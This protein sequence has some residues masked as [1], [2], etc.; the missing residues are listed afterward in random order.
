MMKKH[1]FSYR[2]IVI[3]TVLALLTLVVLFAIAAMYPFN[4][5]AALLS[6][7]SLPVPNAEI[8]TWSTFTGVGTQLKYPPGWEGHIYTTQGGV[9]NGATYTFIWRDGQTLLAQID[10]LEVVTTD[11]T[12]LD[13]EMSYWQQNG[14]THNYSLEQVMAQGYPAWWIHTQ[15]SSGMKQPAGILWVAQ[16]ERSYRFRLYSQVDVQASSEQWLR[17]MVSTFQLATVDWG[18]TATKLV[19][20]MRTKLEESVHTP[21]AVLSVTYNRGQ[22]L[23]YAETYYNMQDNSDG[24]YLWYGGSTLDCTY[25]D[26]DEARDGA[27]FVN[28]AVAAGG[29]PIPPL[30]P[31]WPDAAKSVWAL[32]DWLQGDGWTV[33][34]AEQ[35]EV[36]DVVIMGPFND[37]CWTGLVVDGG[38]VPMLATHSGEYWTT[39]SQLWCWHNDQ[40]TYE[41][42]YL[43]APTLTASPTPT[44][45]RTPTPTPNQTPTPGPTSTSTPVPTATPTKPSPVIK[46]RAGWNCPTEELEAPNTTPV[47]QEPVM[48]IVHHT[49]SRND[50][51][52]ATEDS[53][54]KYTWA[55]WSDGWFGGI[56][57]GTVSKYYDPIKD[58]WTGEV[59]M[60]WLT[61]R[62]NMEWTDTAYHYL[63]DG[64]GNIYQGSYYGIEYEKGATCTEVS[65]M[66]QIALVGCFEPEECTEEGG[67]VTP[68]V[69]T[70]DSLEMLIEWLGCNQRQFLLPD[71]GTVD[72][73]K[74]HRDVDDGS[75]VGCGTT[76]CPGQHLYDL[77]PDIRQ[78]SNCGTSSIQVKYVGWET[79]N[80]FDEMS[81]D[82]P[83]Y[84]IILMGY[85]GAKIYI[86]DPDGRH[87]GIEPSSGNIVNQI[88]GAK[89]DDNPTWGYKAS[90]GDSMILPTGLVIAYIPYPVEGIY[91]VQAHG[92]LGSMGGGLATSAWNVGK[93]TAVRTIFVESEQ[94]LST[95]YKFVYSPD[96]RELVTELFEQD[97]E[98]PVTMYLASGKM[99][100]GDWFV[101]DV[102]I[103]FEAV[104]DL[105]GSQ[106]TKYHI[107]EG[108]WITYT[109][110]FQIVVEGTRVLEYNSVDWMGNREI[111]RTA[112]FR[113]DK[114]AP[115]ITVTQA[116][117]ATYTL[118]S[119]FGI[120]Y[121]AADAVSGMAQVTA[122]LSGQSIT[123]G[124]SLEAFFLGA[125]YH[126]LVITAQD[127]AGWLT[128]YTDFVQIQA[129]VKD[130]MWLHQQILAR[131]WISGMCPICIVEDL[132]AKLETVIVERDAERWYT[133]TY[134]LY[135]YANTVEDLIDDHITPTGARLLIRGAQYIT[136]R[137]K[138]QILVSPSFG[139]SLYA[140][141]LAVRAIFAPHAVTELAIAHYQSLTE[142]QAITLS[143]QMVGLPFDFTTTQ[144]P[145]ATAISHFQQPVT[146][147][148]WYTNGG[149][150]GIPEG[151][152]ALH[153][154]N[155]SRWI[156]MPTVVEAAYNRV[157][158]QMGQFT[159]YALLERKDYI[160]LPVVLRNWR[161]Q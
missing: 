31:D 16:G 9:S 12:N 30:F 39:A 114:T 27:H 25:H 53:K 19:P 103:L 60:V 155:N 107:N 26:G 154:W 123:S 100:N 130:L 35:A 88:P 143:Q 147:T 79:S 42:V 34:T 33:T 66:I 101:T 84:D 136:T 117:S 67:S 52:V 109:L 68:S 80:Q 44:P 38:N 110:P 55:V 20:P 142:T 124:Q 120:I 3:V 51:T 146:I 28:Q 4:A 63:I 45:S 5:T 90:R 83:A 98:S 43:H 82:Q 85:E 74:G 111:T 13:A 102:T 93:N 24:C 72:N 64:A 41:K 112:Q 29:R 106:F 59:L 144:Y 161:A 157:A 40:Q 1:R 23:A 160:Y 149:L 152:L 7:F 36:G 37:P 10:L 75:N 18:R 73:I 113:L 56:P 116:S 126:E 70:I 99:G 50:P 148:T 61:E 108:S 32:R 49:D 77:L 87:L 78:R 69:A 158:A 128:A 46:D 137:W 150:G 94:E 11:T 105:S 145:S 138:Q 140:P 6:E 58:T 131:G 129:T 132:D 97:T 15:E 17:Q 47:S 141:D 118:S 91:Q 62:Y 127:Q 86:T 133:A 104:D 8:D 89:F 125:G 81:T 57:K 156:E 76:V 2:T 71:G 22:A 21:A 14:G 65:Q 153:Y 159:I 135:D 151:R 139:G 48:V 54:Q 122:T 96:N 119:T 92:Q 134:A 95:E 121:E 115:V